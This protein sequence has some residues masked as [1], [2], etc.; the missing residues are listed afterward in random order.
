MTT[1]PIFPA[2]IFE[3]IANGDAE[4]LLNMSRQFRAKVEDQARLIRQEPILQQGATYTPASDF[5]SPERL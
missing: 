5:V 4:A 3:Q 2:T 1:M